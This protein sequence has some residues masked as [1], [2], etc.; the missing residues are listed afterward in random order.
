LKGAI[1]TLTQN[2][3]KRQHISV[4]HVP[5]AFELIAGTNKM[6]E[7]YE[8]YSGFI[9][10]GCVIKGETD[11]DQYINQAVVNSVSSMIMS[12][13]IPIGL[14]LLTV[15]SMEQAI[16]RSGGKYGN[17]GSESA[18]AVLAVLS[19]EITNLEEE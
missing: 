19:N 8:N 9:V 1:E 4:L 15:N 18:L 14:G 16:D 11:H 5:G 12:T 2:K 6:L 17:K 7:Y 10:L 13:N 3:V